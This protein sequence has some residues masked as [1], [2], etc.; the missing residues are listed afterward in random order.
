M[1]HSEATWPIQTWLEPQ[2]AFTCKSWKCWA[3]LCAGRKGNTLYESTV[4]QREASLHLYVQICVVLV[5]RSHAGWAREALREVYQPE[6]L[7]VLVWRVGS[8]QGPAG[9]ALL[10]GVAG[11]CVCCCD[12][13]LCVWERQ[14]RSTGGMLQVRHSTSQEHSSV[15]ARNNKW[16]EQKTR[17]SVS[18]ARQKTASAE[19]SS[20]VF[21]PKNITRSW[22]TQ[23][24]GQLERS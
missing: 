18:E 17:R 13:T 22:W 21:P 6:V 8:S 10:L 9:R 12:Y 5:L 4:I 1:T 11:Y 14:P 23:N 7:L 24:R 2:D 20:T 3:A 15:L 19:H 16:C